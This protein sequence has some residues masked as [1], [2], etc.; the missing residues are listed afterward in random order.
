MWKYADI[1][2]IVG[3]VDIE[4]WKDTYDRSCEKSEYELTQVCKQNGEAYGNK[5][6]TLEF[7]GVREMEIIVLLFYGNV[8]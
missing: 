3:K 2:M 6:I 7:G 5:T 1:N 4:R 8:S